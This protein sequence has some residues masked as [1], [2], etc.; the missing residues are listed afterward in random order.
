[1]YEFQDDGIRWLAGRPKGLLGDEPGLGK[2]RQLLLAAEGATLVVAPAM[3][4]GVWKDEIAR[5]RPDL[6]VE[7][8]PYTKLCA[9]EK[10]PRGGTV[11]LPQLKPE[12]R[13]HY[14]TLI[15]DEA[16]YLKGRKTTWSLAARKLTADR[17]WMAT[18]TPIPNWAQDLFVLIQMLHDAGDPR[19]SS[20]WRWAKRW[21]E[22][23]RVFGLTVGNLLDDSDAGWA[24][25]Q[26]ANLGGVFL[27]RT[28]DD[29]PE[30][31]P[32]LR[33]QTIECKMT[34]AQAKFYRELKKNYLATLP[35]IGVEVSCWSAGA[36]A[37]QLVRVSTG[38]ES[39]HSEARGSG[40]LNVVRE[41]LLGWG[42]APAVLACHF[43]STV[44]ALEQ[45]VVDVGR[46]PV[47]VDGDTPPDR[48]FALAKQFQEG[49]GDTLVASIESVAEGLT[50]TRADRMVFVEKSYRPSRNEQV[51]RR[52]RRIGQ[53]RPVLEIDLVTPGTVD[54]RIRS[55]LTKK[56]DQQMKALPA[57]EFAGL[58]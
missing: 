33:R 21:F 4:V 54:A 20:Y 14:D 39:L 27:R 7:L 25:F 44:R 26:R 16:H 9:T 45:L 49:R 23:Y 37:T 41:L 34:P 28:W 36:L 58:L 10:G 31:L 22:V 5:W 47:V 2:T 52:I 3:L 18:G 40:K 46:E 56:T 50:L 35:E 11:P 15:F 19:W 13:R 32:P 38:L 1:M 43:K 6:D 51:S 48:R 55:L 53:D 8:V 29:V 57:A 24:E 42:D 12:Y 17:L 30:Q